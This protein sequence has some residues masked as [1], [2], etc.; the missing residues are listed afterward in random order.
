MQLRHVP[1][2]L[3]EIPVKGCND[4]G[5]FTY[6]AANALNRAGANISHGKDARNARLQPAS[7]LT[8]T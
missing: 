4:G 6:G 3:G 1:L 5:P 7:A 8:Q 2:L